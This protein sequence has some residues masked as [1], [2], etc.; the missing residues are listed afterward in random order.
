VYKARIL[1]DWLINEKDP[2]PDLAA[3]G[4]GGQGN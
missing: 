4:R 3:R 1:G 2:V